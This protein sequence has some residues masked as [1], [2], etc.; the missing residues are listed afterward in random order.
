MCNPQLY[1]YGEHQSVEIAH[2]LTCLFFNAVPNTAHTVSSWTRPITARCFSTTL[3]VVACAVVECSCCRAIAQR[4]RKR[5]GHAKGLQVKE[6]TSLLS[7]SHTVSCLAVARHHRH[8]YL[9]SGSY[10]GTVS[11]WNVSRRRALPT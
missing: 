7:Y 9:I 8:D 10:H 2:A 6:R 11:I 1:S 3:A 5:E 4:Q